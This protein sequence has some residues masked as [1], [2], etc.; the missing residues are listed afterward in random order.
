M[1]YHSYTTNQFYLAENLSLLFYYFHKKIYI[2]YYCNVK[3]TLSQ[4][5]NYLTCIV[6]LWS[7]ISTLDALNAY[8][9]Y[10]PFESTKDFKTL[11]YDLYSR[12]NTINHSLFLI[13]SRLNSFFKFQFLFVFILN[14]FIFHSFNSQIFIRYIFDTTKAF[15]IHEIYLFI[16]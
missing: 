5:I 10:E 15:V 9:Q 11:S 13:M 6:T 7:F 4:V 16:I 1:S 8:F 2:I 14:L 3:I 12:L